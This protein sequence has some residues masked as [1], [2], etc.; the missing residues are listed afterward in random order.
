MTR[1]PMD[2]TIIPIPLRADLTIYVQGLPLDL[3]PAEAAKIG[4]VITALAT[5]TAP[6]MR[7]TGDV[8]NPS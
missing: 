2:D 6:P 7:T 1:Y 4:R 8:R 5:S 3:T